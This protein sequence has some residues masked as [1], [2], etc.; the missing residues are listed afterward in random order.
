MHRG[1]VPASCSDEGEDED[2][3]EK[4][5]IYLGAGIGIGN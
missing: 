2:K 1:G 3:V 4:F 5:E